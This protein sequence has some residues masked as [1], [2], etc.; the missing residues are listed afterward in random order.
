MFILI[1]ARRIHEKYLKSK[2]TWL[3]VQTFQ[4]ATT[5]M[6]VLARLGMF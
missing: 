3:H 4:Y 2:I 1:T 5:F 6:S